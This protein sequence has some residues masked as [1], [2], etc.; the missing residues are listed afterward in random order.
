MV[1]VNHRLVPL[2]LD[3]VDGTTFELFAQAF[4]AVTMGRE[5]IPLGGTHDGG[6]DGAFERG[7]F[8]SKSSLF[9]QASIQENF[10]QKIRDTVRRLK[11][12]GR[13]PT[14]LVYCTSRVIP[15]LDKEAQDLSDELGVAIQIRDQKYIDAH[16]NSAPGTVEAF[17]SYLAPQLD[18]LKHI[19][20][21]TIVSSELPIRALCVFLGQEVDRRRGDTELQESVTDGLIL[22]ALEETNADDGVFMTR[23]EVL[24]KIEGALPTAKA[25]VRGTIDA[26]LKVMSSK[27]GVKGREIRHYKDGDKYCLAFE[28]RQLIYR[29]NEEDESLKAEVTS[30]FRDRASQ[31]DGADLAELAAEICHQTLNLTFEKQGLEIAAF[32][33]GADTAGEESQF[34]ISEN[35][36]EALERAGIPPAD[37]PRIK[38]VALPVLRQAFYG[39]TD[40][41]RRYLLKLGRTYTLLLSLMNEP[42]IVEYFRGMSSKFV[43]YVGSDLIVRALSE[44]YLDPEDQMTVNTFR[45]LKA[46]GAELILTEPALME[47]YTHLQSADQ[48]F[49]NHYLD[50]EKELN[51]DWVRHIDRIMIRAYFYARQNPD[52]GRR[53]ANWPAFIDQFCSYDQLYKGMGRESLRLTLCEEF[54]F[55]FEDL[56]TMSRGVDEDELQDLAEELEKVM[57]KKDK[58]EL[59]AKNDALQILRIYARRRELGE[60]HKPNPYGYRTWWLTQATRA[61]QVTKKLVDDKGASYMMRPEFLLNFISLNPSL[62]SVQR[63]FDSIFPS[64][65]GVRLSNRMRDDAFKKVIKRVKEVHALGEGRARALVAELSDRLKG[66][67]FIEYEK[68]LWERNGQKRG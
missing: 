44:R 33:D 46:A 67:A 15:L 39:S 42:R 8:E 34:T 9:M 48:E 54:G 53:P 21:A 58:A 64:L 13:T 59:L 19:G 25:F 11:E 7:L 24:E 65:I 1:T 5:F 52:L 4:M 23:S 32:M 55:T 40:P 56:D 3:R 63:S 28:T 50:V 35:M 60:I 66:D 30:I 20:A 26:R 29:E 12:V 61:L 22:W 18:Y 36:D 51:L 43:L 6:A 17:Q 45:I 62:E 14:T 57:Q 41:E 49:K 31:S 10:R 27:G 47:V 38:E 2:A 37:R 68:E 16:I